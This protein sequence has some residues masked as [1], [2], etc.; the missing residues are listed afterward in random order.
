MRASMP[1]GGGRQ[2]KAPQKSMENTEKA[3]ARDQNT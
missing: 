2:L 3:S 1:R